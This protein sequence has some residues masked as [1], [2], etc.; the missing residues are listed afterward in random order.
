VQWYR[1]LRGP[2]L[3]SGLGDCPNNLILLSPSPEKVAA[4][5][6]QH[7]PQTNDFVATSCDEWTAKSMDRLIHPS[8]WKVNSQKFGEVLY[9]PSA[10]R[11][12]APAHLVPVQVGVR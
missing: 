3:Y 10:F 4:I 2:P 11:L 5:G 8:A 6:S 7:I 12:H 9:R 1:D